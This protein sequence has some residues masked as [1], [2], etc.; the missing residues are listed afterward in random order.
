MTTVFKPFN[1]ALVFLLLAFALLLPMPHVTAPAAT[2]PVAA[3]MHI[4]ESQEIEI[5]FVDYPDQWHENDCGLTIYLRIVRFLP[6]DKIDPCTIITISWQEL[7]ARAA[8]RL[9]KQG[10][11]MDLPNELSKDVLYALGQNKQFVA[12]VEAVLNEIA[13]SQGL[14]DNIPK[15]L[16]EFPFDAFTH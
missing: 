12:A 15:Y 5:H 14:G 6:N 7:Y 13:R 4:G 8:A 11:R 1:F 3:I 10:I 16:T 9:Q 2:R